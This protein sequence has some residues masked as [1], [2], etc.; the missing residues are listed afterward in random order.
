[1]FSYIVGI[2]GS[3]KN[4]FA[5][6]IF[7]PVTEAISYTTRSIRPGEVNGEDYHFVTR[8]HFLH[9]QEVEGFFAETSLY[10][11]EWYGM[12]I[13]ELQSKQYAIVDSDGVVNTR[14]YLT[15]YEIILLDL[16]VDDMT[17]RL[18]QRGESSEI[19]AQRIEQAYIDKSK[20]MLLLRDPHTIVLNALL[21][22]DQL[23]ERYYQESKLRKHRFGNWGSPD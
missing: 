11:N 22:I 14:H 10:A 1:M 6:A 13:L 17:K 3:G 7:N 19:I 4:T 12:P 5:Q 8:E 15:Q 23:R 21:P 9:L 2:S 20:Q 16:S 18:Q